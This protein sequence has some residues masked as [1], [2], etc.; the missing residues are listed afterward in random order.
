MALASV[1]RTGT[2]T[3]GLPVAKCGAGTTYNNATT[4]SDPVCDTAAGY[5]YATNSAGTGFCCKAGSTPCQTVCC[6]SGQREV[7]NT[8]HCCNNGATYSNGACQSPTTA[9][10]PRSLSGRVVGDQLTLTPIAV[11]GMEANRNNKLCPS[12]LA[13]CPITVRGGGEYE[14]LDSLNDLQ[15]CGGCASLGTDQDCTAIK[16]ARWMGCNLGLCEVYSCRPGW[17]KV[18]DGKSC[19]RL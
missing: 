13:A 15:S 11:F 1:H 6:P 4:N 7:G 8:G 2:S 16:G 19:G 18:D 5:Q 9:A 14:C 10:K 17:T 3:A 12:G